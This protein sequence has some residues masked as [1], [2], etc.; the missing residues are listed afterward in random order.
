MCIDYDR[1]LDLI[2][3]KPC[4]SSCLKELKQPFSWDPDFFLNNIE[5]CIEQYEKE[6]LRNLNEKFNGT[7]E[8]MEH[9]G[10]DKLCNN[11]YNNKKIKYLNIA[12]FKS[13]NLN[14]VMCHY[15][16]K[17]NDREVYIYLTLLKKLET[18]KNIESVNISISGEPFLF[19]KEI[20]E[21]FEKTKFQKYILTNGT[22]LN[23]DDLDRLSK[24]NNIKFT[25][26]IDGITKE[27]YEK[28]RVGA[29]FE[30]VYDN[31]MYAKKIGLLYEVH[32]VMQELNKSETD[33][34][35][36]F[37]ESRDI[38]LVL[39]VAGNINQYT[40]NKRIVERYLKDREWNTKL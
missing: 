35:I 19:K 18:V 39:L 33:Y 25:I 9:T 29:N 32:Y 27:N 14:C 26:S 15:K 20:F 36:D 8:F 38:K 2:F 24:F 12:I 37:F 5:Y 30:K 4:S 1:N 21:F 6:N 28:I 3:F 11:F 31:M 16:Q 22:L 23:H 17:F 7:C 40:K 10:F 34:V 13:C